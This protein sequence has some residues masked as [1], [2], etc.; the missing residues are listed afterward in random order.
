[1]LCA[2]GQSNNLLGN[3]G[4]LPPK[5][6]AGLEMRIRKHAPPS[7]NENKKIS[8]QRDKTHCGTIASHQKKTKSRNIVER[9]AGPLD[10]TLDTGLCS[11]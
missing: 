6:N 11:M 10:G 3:E 7:P 8:R 2:K 4:R 1:M 9:I 5:A